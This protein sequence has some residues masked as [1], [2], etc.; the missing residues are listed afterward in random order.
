MDSVASVGMVVVGCQLQ[1]YNVGADEVLYVVAN[2]GKSC[3]KFFLKVNSG[4]PKKGNG[5]FK[6]YGR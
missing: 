6:G 2:F 1:W 3:G 4:V 5:N